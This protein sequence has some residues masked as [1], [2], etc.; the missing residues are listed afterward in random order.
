MLDDKN[1]RYFFIN[2]LCNVA[3]SLD[4]KVIVE[5][6]ENESQWHTLSK[7]PLDGVQGFYIQ[8]PKP[9]ANIGD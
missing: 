6:V 5:A 8:H 2:T 7:L 9:I 1:D 4:I 3:H